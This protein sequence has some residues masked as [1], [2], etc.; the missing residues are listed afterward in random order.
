MQHR[1]H[2]SWWEPF[3]QESHQA[4]VFEKLK[5][6]NQGV[7]LRVVSATNL[8]LEPQKMRGL[9][10]RETHVTRPVS[11]PS[12]PP[13]AAEKENR[14]YTP[15][16]QATPCL[17]TR[18]QHTCPGEHGKAKSALG[19]APQGY[20]ETHHSMR[21]SRTPR[22]LNV[23][24]SHV[25][26]EPNLQYS[27]T[28]ILQADPCTTRQAVRNR[29]RDPDTAPVCSQAH[30]ARTV[31]TSGRWSHCW[32]NTTNTGKGAGAGSVV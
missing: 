15:Q 24:S 28:I 25:P 20:R 5:T 29:W 9:G 2:A 26:W 27:T 14:S 11:T 22:R 10:T 32:R 23:G 1:F 21:C 13:A 7:E 17:Q 3:Q 4:A 12:Q 18:P 16:R 31:T 6:T 8:L 19:S 30:K